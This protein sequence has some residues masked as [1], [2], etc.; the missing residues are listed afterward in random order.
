MAIAVGVKKLLVYKKETS[1]GV[2]AGAASANYLRRVTSDIDL[3]KDTY[4]SNE[5]A[6]HQQ[7]QDFRHGVRRVGGGIQAELSTLTY[8]PFFAAL[9]RRDFT[10]G[11]SFTASG[12]ETI[13]STT[14]TF[15]RSAGS[16]LT[17]GFKV[18]DVVRWTTLAD[19]A[20]N[21]K[22]FRITALVA[23]TMTVAETVVAN[24]VADSTCACSVVGKKTFIPT[25]GHTDDSFTIEHYYSDLDISEQF[26]GCKPASCAI[27]L[28]PTG[29]ATAN[30]AF[31]GQDRVVSSAGSAPYF[32]SPSADTTTG[33]LAAI[34]GSLRIGSTDMAIVTG[35]TLNIE[36]ALTGDPVVGANIL[37]ILAQGRVRVSGQATMYFQDTTF[38]EAFQNET[39]TSMVVKLNQSGAEPQ[40]F[41][42][43]VLPRLKF[44]GA[45][46][47]DGEKALVQ[48]LPFQA[49]LNST[50][51][52]GV[53]SEA[54]T[55][56]IQDSDA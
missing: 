7:M 53:S 16:W 27:S 31:M 41:L 40:S 35:L 50:G 8:A 1:W 23:L 11:A 17:D 19:A 2:A 43:I 33:V 5:I 49:L 21:G 47:D 10:A 37:P 6:S 46:K 29:M 3:S 54:T 30:F 28:P 48:T 4:Q 12:G 52:A 42:N 15:V 25:S 20:N 36:S 44:G 13:T 39:E 26:L 18:G 24:A 51:G 55:M 38:L 34:N 56:S 9:L 32:T 22:N 14:S 45:T